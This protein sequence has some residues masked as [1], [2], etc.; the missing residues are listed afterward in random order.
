MKKLFII[1][2]ITALTAF[3]FCM[4]GADG[5]YNGFT[6][7]INIEPTGKGEVIEEMMDGKGTEVQLTAQAIATNYEFSH[8]KGD[9]SSEDNPAT[10]TM[11]QDKTITAVFAEPKEEGWLFMM[12]MD[13]DNN[14]ENALW[15]DINEMEYGLYQLDQSG[16]DISKIHFMILWD[17]ASNGDSELF[18]LAPDS[19]ENYT[20]SSNTI[21]HTSEKWWTGNEVNVGDGDNVTAFL[22][23]AEA[24]YPD[25][26]HRMLMFSNHGGGPGKD[27]DFPLKAVCWDDTNGGDYLSTSE[28]RVSVENAG[29]GMGNKLSIIGFDVCMQGNIEEAYEHRNISEYFVASPESEGGDGWEFNDWIPRIS[30]SMMSPE[31]LSTEIVMSFKDNFAGWGGYY[32]YDTL[33]AANLSEMD[34]LK[35]AIDELATA[36][37]TDNKISE[38][39]SI[40]NSTH[41]YN[42][43]YLHEFG[44]FCMDLESSSNMTTNI[45]NKATATSNALGKSIVYAWADSNGGNYDGRGDVIKRGLSISATTSI[46]GEGYTSLDFSNSTTSIGWYELINQW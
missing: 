43:S 10:V 40:M 4:P 17:G 29:F 36:I 42:Y 31:D 46:G 3:L 45:K 38:A 18:E 7:T 5:N 37:V 26:T 41:S 39:K 34:N 33:T 27:A 20:L 13:G 14:L 16:V 8:W 19:S 44:E 28:I 22:T 12:Y 6:L 35:Q 15:T 32:S 24:K 11:D 23:W 2:A 21:N 1:I 9:L 30:G 25:Y